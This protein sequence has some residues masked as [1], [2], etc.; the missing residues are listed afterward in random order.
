MHKLEEHQ[1][2]ILKKLAVLKLEMLS[3]KEN[4]LKEYNLNNKLSSPMKVTGVIT[5]S[6]IVPL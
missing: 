5:S 2:E 3:M 1:L 4:L 6:L